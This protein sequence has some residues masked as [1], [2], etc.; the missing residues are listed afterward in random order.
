MSPMADN[1]V[2]SVDIIDLLGHESDASLWHCILRHLRSVVLAA[3][4]AG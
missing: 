2:P 3:H 4:D 1:K